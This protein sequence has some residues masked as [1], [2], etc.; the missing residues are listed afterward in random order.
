M[1][2]RIATALFACCFG[3]AIAISTTSTFRVEAATYPSAA[4]EGEQ[5]YH[6]L[7]CA[8]CHGEHGEGTPQGIRIVSEDKPINDAVVMKQVHNGGADMPAFRDAISDAQITKII[9]FMNSERD[10]LTN[11]DKH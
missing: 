5:L 10:K 6:T 7:S 4:K 3:S 9:A 1:H 2:T 11:K 8:N